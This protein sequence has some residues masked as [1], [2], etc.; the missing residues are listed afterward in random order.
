M[1]D[2][3]TAEIVTVIPVENTEEKKKICRIAS[4]SC[5]DAH[6]FFWSSMLFRNYWE[7]AGVQMS[8]LHLSVKEECFCPSSRMYE[9]QHLAESIYS[10]SFWLFVVLCLLLSIY[11][12]WRSNNAIKSKR[13]NRFH[14]RKCPLNRN[15][16]SCVSE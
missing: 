12:S 4:F 16:F 14:H 11:E 6:C 10:S 5:L 15:M 3:Q 9:S 7:N 2:V 1:E 13:R 8:L